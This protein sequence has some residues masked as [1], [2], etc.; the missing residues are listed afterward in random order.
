MDNW[1]CF[2]S[3]SIAEFISTIQYVY[4]VARV[5]FELH[6]ALLPSVTASSS[7]CFIHCLSHSFLEPLLH[8]VTVSSS[9]YFS[10]SLFPRVTASWVT[11]SLSHCFIE[12]LLH[13]VTPLVTPSLSHCFIDSL[14][15][16][17]TVSSSHCFSHFLLESIVTGPETQRDTCGQVS[18]SWSYQ[19][20]IDNTKDNLFLT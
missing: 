2:A 3:T 11:A 10:E 19:Y 8:S 9:H 18:V 12:L 15:P 7:H 5:S 13:C 14:L 4:Q 17:V 16:R 20:L 6:K 1:M